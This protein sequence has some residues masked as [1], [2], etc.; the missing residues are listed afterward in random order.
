MRVEKILKR[1]NGD[2]VKIITEFHC[3]WHRNEHEWSFRIETCGK[4]KRK[5][6]GIIDEDHY[7]YRRLSNPDRKEYE[8]EKAL[9]FVSKEEVLEASLDVWGEL[10]PAV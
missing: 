8:K 7:K 9:Q 10:I 1:D 4:G 6:R 3:E 2:R 5:W